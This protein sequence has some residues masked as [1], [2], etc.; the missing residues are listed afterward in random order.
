MPAEQL[1]RAAFFD[2]GPAVHGEVLLQARGMDLRTLERQHNARVAPRVLKLAL[3]AGQVVGDELLAV[4]PDP[5]AR[6][7]RRAVLAE[8]DEMGERP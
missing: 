8:C 1:G 4:E 3:I 5:D 7:L 6:H 2:P